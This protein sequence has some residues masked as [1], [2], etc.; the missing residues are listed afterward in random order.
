M[1]APP[2]IY[3][4]KPIVSHSKARE[5]ILTRSPKTFSW[6]P[7]GEKVFEFFRLKWY[8]LVHF[9]ILSNGG[10]GKHHA[11]WGSLSPLPILLTGLYITYRPLCQIHLNKRLTALKQWSLTAGMSCTK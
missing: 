1:Y 7:S 8:T 10:T 11:D 2:S 6:G 5:N 9:I 3:I 4:T